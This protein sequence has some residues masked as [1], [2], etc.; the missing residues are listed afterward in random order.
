MV[1]LDEVNIPD[2]QMTLRARESVRFLFHTW[3]S[4]NSFQYAMILLGTIVLCLLYELSAFYL[5]RL[6]AEYT[7]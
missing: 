5:A 6:E 1:N 2:L 4:Y 7:K 3:K